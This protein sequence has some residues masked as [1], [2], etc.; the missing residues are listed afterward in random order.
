MTRTRLVLTVAVV[1]VLLPSGAR[2]QAEEMFT[3]PLRVRLHGGIGLNPDAN[4]IGYTGGAQLAIA[5]NATQS[6]GPA[7]AYVQTQDGDNGRFLAVG[8]FVEERLFNAFLLSIGGVGYFPTADE[9]P[10]PF[11]IASK[12]AYA[13]T[14]GVLSPYAGI[15]IDQIFGVETQSLFSA[16]LG[17]TLAFGG[18]DL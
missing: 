5:A 7:V 13:P 3:Y 2:A 15:R 14:W 18:E 16:D 10:V 8:L 6:W 11:G 17:V 4:D 9:R 1:L 12:F